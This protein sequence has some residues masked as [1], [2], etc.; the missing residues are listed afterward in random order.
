MIQTVNKYL[1][2]FKKPSVCTKFQLSLVMLNYLLTGGGET[3]I[4]ITDHVVQ[5]V[6][7]TSF[8]VSTESLSMVTTA[9]LS[10]CDLWRMHAMSNL[11]CL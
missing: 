8:P 1:C 10:L 2:N 6:V 11:T 4:Q 5:P 9:G 7:T 3:A